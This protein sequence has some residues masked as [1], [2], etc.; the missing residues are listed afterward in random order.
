MIPPL[1]AE[2]IDVAHASLDECR[3]RVSNVRNAPLDIHSAHDQIL[4]DF[5]G[6]PWRG[7]LKGRN[8]LLLVGFGEDRDK[9]IAL[10]VMLDGDAAPVEPAV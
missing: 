3:A 9:A 4:F 6:K 1:V 7:D 5:D 2:L 8:L 10:R